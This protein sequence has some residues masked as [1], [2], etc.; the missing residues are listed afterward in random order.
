MV[1]EDGDFKI[2]GGWGWPGDTQHP[3][4]PKLAYRSLGDAVTA[5]WVDWRVRI[6]FSADPDRGRVSVW[7]DG[8]RVLRRWH[9]PG[10]TLYPH[11]SSYLKI[12]YYRSPSVP[13]TGT[14]YHDNWV[15][16]TPR[17]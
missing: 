14:V 16:R 15:V 4:E 5:R 1:I 8:R 17:S 11:L 13:G 9:P 3:T 2:G 7:R 10:G 12:G 6:R